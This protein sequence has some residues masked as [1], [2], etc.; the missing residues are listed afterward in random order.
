MRLREGGREIGGG[1][2]RDWRGREGERGGWRECSLVSEVEN[3][4]GT[5][6]REEDKRA[7]FIELA[8]S[9]SGGKVGGS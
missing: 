6:G 8:L 3:N 7:G 9:V 2:E 4:G 5:E 1:R